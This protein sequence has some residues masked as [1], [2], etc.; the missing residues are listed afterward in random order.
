MINVAATGTRKSENERATRREHNL[1]QNEIT[2]FRRL[3]DSS[4]TLEMISA[5]EGRRMMGLVHQFH[6]RRPFGLFCV[7]LSGALALTACQTSRLKEFESVKLGMT[8][9]EV[10]EAT[11]NPTVTRRWQ[12][13]DRWIYKFAA[14]DIES[15]REVHFEN[16]SAVY[17]GEKVKPAVSAA[18]QDRLNEISDQEAAR[19]EAEIQKAWSDAHGAVSTKIDKRPADGQ[20]RSWDVDEARIQEEYHGISNPELEKLKVAPEFEDVAQ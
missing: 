9:S 11:G 8:K 17:V 4:Y 15:V 13:K 12:G 3:N 10:L 2:P 1:S 16:G 7:L 6:G 20:Q 19:R 14:D 18:E 5:A